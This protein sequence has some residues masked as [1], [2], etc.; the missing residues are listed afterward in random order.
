MKHRQLLTAIIAG[1]LGLLVIIAVASVCI[2]AVTASKIRE[3]QTKNSPLLVS[4]NKTLQII[5]DCTTP[6]MPCYD[7]GQAATASAIGD[8]NR[9]AIIAAACASGPVEVSVAEITNCVI[10]RLAAESGDKP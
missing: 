3:T 5:E 2:S 9:V 8:I 4:T 1:G 10:G 6:G 7:R